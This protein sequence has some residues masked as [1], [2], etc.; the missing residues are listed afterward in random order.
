M[1]KLISQGAIVVG[2][3]TLASIGGCSG[4]S[5]RDVT[6]DGHVFHVPSNHLV[7]GKIPW[8][9]ASQSDGL[10]FV[11]N[12]E[13]RPEDQTLVTI[14]ST[15]MTCRPATPPASTQLA[16]ACATA[17]REAGDNQA[18]RDFDVEK[19]HPNGDPTQW[20]YRLKSPRASGQ[21]VVVASCYAMSDSRQAGL[22]T[23]LNNY[24]DLVYSVSLRDS[25][26]HGLPVIWDKVHRTLSSWE[27]GH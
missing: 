5:F 7:Q 9:P 22:C 26:V 4:G 8:L 14:E 25:D 24:K 6:V 19:V 27:Q 18:D 15:K 2:I 13:A 21:G 20:E 23:S 12:P 10:K 16:S 11:L 1:T 17:A 3:L